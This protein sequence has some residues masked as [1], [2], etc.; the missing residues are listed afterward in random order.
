MLLALSL[1]GLSVASQRDCAGHGGG[2][3]RMTLGFGLGEIGFEFDCLVDFVG[4]VQRLEGHDGTRGAL[5][6][7]GAIKVCGRAEPGELKGN[8][9]RS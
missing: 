9:R 8:K 3:K 4:S 6:A 5:S 7:V 2:G 1:D